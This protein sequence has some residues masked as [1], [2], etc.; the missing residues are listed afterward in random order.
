MI[1]TSVYFQSAALIDCLYIFLSSTLSKKK[2]R[3]EKSISRQCG[4]AP[5]SRVTVCCMDEK[6]TKPR[7]HIAREPA[8]T[9]KRASGSLFGFSH[10]SF[11]DLHSSL[12]PQCV[13]GPSAKTR[14]RNRG[15]Q[16][17]TTKKRKKA[18][19]GSWKHPNTISKLTKGQRSGLNARGRAAKRGNRCSASTESRRRHNEGKGGVK[20]EATPTE[21]TFK[22]KQEMQTQTCHNVCHFGGT[23]FTTA[24]WFILPGF[25]KQGGGKNFHVAH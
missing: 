24:K 2:K 5:K 16:K 25:I 6:K 9:V 20:F 1:R 18:K 17:K 11:Y 12:M 15:S 23:G 22:I 13:L 8:C 3:K 7:L 19:G 21:G 4:F 10:H 14:Q